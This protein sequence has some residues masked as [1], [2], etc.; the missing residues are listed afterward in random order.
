MRIKGLESSTGGFLCLPE[1]WEEEGRSQSPQQGWRRAR[2][3][4]AVLSLQGPHTPFSQVPLFSFLLLPGSLFSM[5]CMEPRHSLC[6]GFGV[7]SNELVTGLGL[8]CGGLLM[9]L[10]FSFR[11]PRSFPS[12]SCPCWKILCPNRKTQ[13]SGILC[14][15][16]SV[17]SML[18]SQCK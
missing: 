3:A 6:R 17:E 2:A 16:S 4:P 1:S 9:N 15:S 5:L 7:I 10:V 13:T 8:Y 11:M 18:M 14:K 12:C